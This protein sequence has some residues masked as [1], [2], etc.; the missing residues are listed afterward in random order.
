MPLAA[1]APDLVVALPGP[2]G[3]F[4]GEHVPEEKKVQ[5]I[6]RGCKTVVVF[7]PQPLA[8]YW[9][10]E[11]V[12]PEGRRGGR[13]QDRGEAGVPAGRQHHRLRHRAG[14][15]EAAA[16]PAEGARPEGGQGGRRRPAT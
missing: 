4:Q 9:E 8:G 2:G 15:A 12:Q 14:A 7:S 16:G 11:P 3:V 5:A 6:E 10:E 13:R 1:D